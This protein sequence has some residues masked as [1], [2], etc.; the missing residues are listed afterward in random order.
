MKVSQKVE[1]HK[2]NMKKNSATAGFLASF[3]CFLFCGIYDF[4]MLI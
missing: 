4:F 3:A 2:T 1:N